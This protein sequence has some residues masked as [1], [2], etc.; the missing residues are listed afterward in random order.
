MKQIAKKS[1]SPDKKVRKNN[2]TEYRDFLS[3]RIDA[4]RQGT[5]PQSPA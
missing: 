2:E 4:L 3:K 5:K 1:T